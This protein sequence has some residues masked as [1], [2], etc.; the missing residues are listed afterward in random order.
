MAETP[1]NETSPPP[2]RPFRALPGLPPDG[3][4]T[5]GESALT[6][7]LRA[8]RSGAQCCYVNASS[9]IARR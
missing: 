4:R 1:Q 9:L 7:Q 2:Q 8:P 5:M 6:G 3:R